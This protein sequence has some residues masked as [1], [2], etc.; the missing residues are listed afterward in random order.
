ME[1]ISKINKYSCE[2]KK[3]L[4]TLDPK[5]EVYYSCEF[6][7]EN[8]EEIFLEQ[9]QDVCIPEEEA[10]ERYLLGN[11]DTLVEEYFKK[12]EVI[13]ERLQ[14]HVEDEENQDESSEDT[15][16]YLDEIENA[17]CE[18]EEGSNRIEEIDDEELDDEI[19]EELDEELDEE[20]LE[21]E[22]L[23]ESKNYINFYVPLG[24]T[25]RY[26]NISY[27]PKFDEDF[28]ITGIERNITLEI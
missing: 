4:D 13:K 14:F 5:T 9:L 20:E 16:E 2:I 7:D 15:D 18:R 26:I 3:M 6:E 1:I 28:N 24:A 21:E 27:T 23:E 17:V 19:D 8:L 11:I 25:E 12:P 22:E 10:E